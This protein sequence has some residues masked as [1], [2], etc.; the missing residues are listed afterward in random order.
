VNGRFDKFFEPL[1]GVTIMDT[2]RYQYRVIGIWKTGS[3]VGGT[4]GSAT[5]AEHRVEELK[6]N[7]A[8]KEVRLMTFEIRTTCVK[9]E[10]FQT[11][12]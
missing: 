12:N 1:S 11:G 3:E 8:I 9:D 4:Y 7:Q 2:L 10:V 6:K 5:D